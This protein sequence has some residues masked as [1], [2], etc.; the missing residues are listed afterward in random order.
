MDNNP[1][2]YQ[3]NNAP[4]EPG[5]PFSPPPQNNAKGY[6]IASLSLGIASVCVGFLCCCFAV[7]IVLAGI[8]GV[9]AIVFAIVAKHEADG[10]MPNMALA[11]LVLGII[12]I[13]LCILLLLFAFVIQVYNMELIEELYRDLGLEFDPDAYPYE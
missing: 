9:L 13:V 10:K 6:A 5:T 7:F 2:G 8:C 12:G 3:N 4:F 11:G 1:F